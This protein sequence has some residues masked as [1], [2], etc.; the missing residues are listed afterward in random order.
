MD[1]IKDD[2]F[3][4]LYGQIAQQ[5]GGV[6]PLLQTFLGF[7]RRKTDF[8]YVPP[9]E[10]KA[11]EAGFPAGVAEKMLLSCFREQA[12]LPNPFQTRDEKE[13]KTADKNK[14]AERTSKEAAPHSES[15]NKGK[16]SIQD[17]KSATST[18]AATANSSKTES[19]TSAKAVPV[20]SCP[21]KVP[22]EQRQKALSTVS[23]YNG[24]RTSTFAWSQTLHDVSISLPFKGD[25]TAK[26]IAVDL[27]SQG[28]TVSEK[29]GSRGS[30]RLQFQWFDRVIEDES[31]W[32]LEECR[33]TKLLVI[34]LEK[35]REIW[36]E[37]AF[38]N[39]GDGKIDTTNVRQR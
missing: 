11:K 8:F 20:S 27:T 36:W 10:E 38:A 26:S 12:N 24:S 17:N 31:T 30:D 23:T 16:M 37:T 4:P 7:M 15:E 14:A 9:N 34:T 13:R 3:D 22:E 18:A 25:T 33:G 5:C 29:G 21:W 19:E 32:S 28:V 39:V 1:Y 35:K 2:R 6:L